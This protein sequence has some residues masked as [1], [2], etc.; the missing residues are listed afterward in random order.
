MKH[1]NLKMSIWG[2]L[3]LWLAGFL[4][5]WLAELVYY[6]LRNTVK[7]MK[8]N[9]FARDNLPNKFWALLTLLKPQFNRTPLDIKKNS[10]LIYLNSYMIS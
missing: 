6:V 3:A 4:V 7:K 2:W 8:V 1:A 10:P 9:I 5:G